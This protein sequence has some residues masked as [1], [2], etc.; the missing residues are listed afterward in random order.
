MFDKKSIARNFSR[1][2]HSYDEEASVQI[3]SA[4]NL[5]KI[6]EPHI[7]HPAESKTNILDL[8]SGTSFIANNLKTE[9]SNIF[10]IDLSLAMLN[11]SQKAANIFKIQS[12][13]ETLPLK[14]NT[15]DA[16]TASFSLQ[17]LND[18]T[19]SFSH[20]KRLLK[21]KGVFAFCIPIAG[22]LHELK[23]ANLFNFNDL[24]KIDEVRFSIQQAGFNEIALQQNTIKQEFS[25]ALDAVKS[26]KRLGANYSAKKEQTLTKSKLKEF[27]S[28]CLKNFSNQDKNIEIS[29]N[30]CYFLLK[31]D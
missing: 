12:D 7:I 23:A 1:S 16:I 13:I 30:I 21:A 8:G 22:S 6:V 9:E 27:N 15:F 28:F 29:W 3:I 31:K 10:E 14:E 18:L 26:I 24:P 17:W 19:K 11:Y 2:A 4:R 5:C 25:T 20:L